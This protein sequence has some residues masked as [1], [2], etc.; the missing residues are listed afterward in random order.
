M[1]AAS[2]PYPAR[3]VT[4][5]ADEHEQAETRKHRAEQTE[6]PEDV[7][8][9][10]VRPHSGTLEHEVRRQHEE[11]K[12]GRLGGVRVPAIERVV[13][14]RNVARL[15]AR[16]VDLGCTAGERLHERVVRG[17]R[18][19][20]ALHREH[21][22]K[23]H[24]GQRQHAP[25]RDSACHRRSSTTRHRNPRA[26]AAARA[27]APARQVAGRRPSARAAASRSPQ[28]AGRRTATAGD[29]R[30]P[31]APATPPQLVALSIEGK[32]RL[33]DVRVEWI[34]LLAGCETVGIEV[35]PFVVHAS[36]RDRRDAVSSTAP[37]SPPFHPGRARA[38]PRPETGEG[39][40]RWWNTS[41]MTTFATDESA[42]GSEDASTTRSAHGVSWTSVVSRLRH[43]RRAA[44]RSPSRARPSR[45]RRPRAAK[46]AARTT[47]GRCD[48]G[49]GARATPARAHAVRR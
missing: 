19:A 25:H 6:N 11:R 12:P 24:R 8:R 4:E 45:R 21:V 34:C 39:C 36:V 32:R 22:D 9:I 31:A 44:V 49:A 29:P 40:G 16:L 38:A 3:L 26:E 14:R 7:R 5:V 2:V 35:E 48:A 10:A 46:R 41:S 47:R 30:R 13:R 37:A 27:S 1:T 33:R 15:E 28:R 17:L 42:Y 23:Q 20:G 43:E 18:R